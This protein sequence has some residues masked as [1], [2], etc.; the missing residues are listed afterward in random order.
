MVPPFLAYYG[1]VNSDETVLREAYT[2]IKLVRD[3]LRDPTT[4][5]W[6]HI[7]GGTWQDTGLWGT[8][9]CSSCLLTS[10]AQL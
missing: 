1:A 2:Q 4:G 10:L 8:G 7:E 6:K 5:L 3:V 9:Q